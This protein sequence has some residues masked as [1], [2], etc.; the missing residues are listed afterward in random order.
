MRRSRCSRFSVS[1]TSAWTLT[2]RPVVGSSSS[3]RAGSSAI[4]LASC[5]RCCMPPDS[6]IGRGVHALDREFGGSQRVSRLGAQHV[7]IA[8]AGDQQ[9]LGDVAAG[10]V[11]HQQPEMRVLVDDADVPRAQHPPLDNGRASNRLLSSRSRQ[12]QA[13]SP[14]RACP[15]GSSAAAASICRSRSRRQCPAPR[16]DRRSTST[17]LSATTS[18]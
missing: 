18:P 17:S 9:P 2:S 12:A 7:E 1:S 8:L 3:S 16:R 15:R 6:S 14:R 10:G 4:A 13:V 5:T 11:V